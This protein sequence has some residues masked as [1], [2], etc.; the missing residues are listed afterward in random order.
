MSGPVPYPESPPPQRFP[1]PQGQHPAGPF[2]GSYPGPLPP[3]VQYPKR[4][5]W[6]YIL[7]G[8]AALAVIAAIAGAVFAFTGR[9]ADTGQTLTA[10]TAQPAIQNFLDALADGDGA[11]IARHSLCGL[12]DEVD[13]SESDLVLADLAADGFSKQFGRV[14]VISI[15]K[16]VY[17]SPYQA[18]ALFTMRVE[19]PGRGRG[20]PEAGTDIQAVAQLLQTDGDVLVCS[21]VQRRPVS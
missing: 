20:A 16:L 11:T 13:D 8:V 4:R 2:P 7:I 10:E 21:F 6:R 19:E 3:P 9:S 18:Q 15:D 17:L 12:Y 14:E 1:P 5:P